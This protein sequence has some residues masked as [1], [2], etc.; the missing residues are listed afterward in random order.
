MAPAGQT[1]LCAEIF[2]SPG[3]PAWGQPDGE[4][5]EA[6]AADL[7]GL[8]I[9]ARARI[10]EAWLTRVPAA[11]PS[12][13]LGYAGELQR[14][15]SYL[16]QRFPTLHLLGRTGTFQYLNMDAV[17]RQA[18]DMAAVLGREGGG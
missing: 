12:Y 9:V 4:L 1:S 18:L 7:A 15:R 2:C 5:I 6:V 13:R 8:G 11:Y 14:V 3:E 17:I 10:R 16:A